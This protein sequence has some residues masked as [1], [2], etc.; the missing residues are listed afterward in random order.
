MNDTRIVKLAKEAVFEKRDV[1]GEIALLTAQIATNKKQME[2]GL[3]DGSI[4]QP[5]A[6]QMLNNSKR[7]DL[8]VDIYAGSGSTLIACEKTGR[9]FRGVEIDPHYCQVILDRWKQFS[10]KAA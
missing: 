6:K 8:C 7:G 10:G 1:E 2:E 4:E 5:K 9:K 3:K